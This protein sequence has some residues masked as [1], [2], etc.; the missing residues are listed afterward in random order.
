MKALWTWLPMIATLALI[1]LLDWLHLGVTH[2][3]MFVTVLILWCLG[4][5]LWFKSQEPRPPAAN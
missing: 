2:F 1:R 3:T 4:L 5:V